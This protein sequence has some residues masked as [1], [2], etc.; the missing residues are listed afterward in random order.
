[1]IPDPQNMKE[2]E[3]RNR[4]K[5]V[6]SKITETSLILDVYDKERNRIIKDLDDIHKSRK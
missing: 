5:F 3:L 2:F 4:L 1:M 6:E